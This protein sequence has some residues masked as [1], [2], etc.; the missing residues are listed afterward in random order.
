MIKGVKIRRCY[1]NYVEDR[2]IDRR[3]STTRLFLLCTGRSA[4]ARGG[5][6][7]GRSERAAFHS[8]QASTAHSLPAFLYCSRR[9]FMFLFFSNSVPLASFIARSWVSRALAFSPESK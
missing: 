2:T 8:S 9:D 6:A 3:K 5:N 4:R 7:P 1:L